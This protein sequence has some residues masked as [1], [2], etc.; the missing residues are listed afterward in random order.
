M[1]R[2]L[3]LTTEFPPVIYGGLGTAVGGWVR[4]SAREGMSVGVLL[5]EGQLV[6]DDPGH[7][8][9]YGAAHAPG[10]HASFGQ[11]GEK[12]VVDRQGI[13]FFQ[14]GWHDAVETGVRLARRWEPDIIHLHTAMVWP[15]AQAIQ[16]RTAKP[17]VYHVHSVDRAE[18]EIGE[19]PYPWLAHSEAQEEAIASADRLIA[20]SRDERDLLAR[21][22]PKVQHRIRVVGN[23]I[24]DSGVATRAAARGRAPD[25]PVV[26]YSGR[27]VERKGIRELLAA[28]PG[29]IEA[30]P[31][32]RFVLAGG[33]PP[34][35]GAEVA[36]QWLTPELEP[37]LGRIH[38]T[39]WLS[40]SE[41]Y[42][43]YRAAD[44]LV[45]PSRYE[46]FGMVILEGMLHGLPIVAA[47]VGGPAEIL[48]HGRTGLLFAPRDADGLGEALV[49]LLQNADLRRHMG[50]A[51]AEKVRCAWTWPKRVASMRRVYDEL[52]PPAALS[53]GD[54]CVRGGMAV[55]HRLALV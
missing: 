26:L 48:E 19:E 10:G 4:A 17:L 42:R 38:F 5:I 16:A 20:L 29:V 53:T 14:A 3:H 44:I 27:L 6:I 8:A 25:M 52:L 11:W 22:Y 34:L 13:T 1:V 41:L 18:Y 23:G 24:D 40:P 37:H 28:I 54:R 33:P 2:I 43:W 7:A 32:C 36:A 35:R 15:V 51:G 12:G 47:N 21:Y 50:R 55:G 46:P 9:R 49:A 31:N 45:V 39:G 30:A